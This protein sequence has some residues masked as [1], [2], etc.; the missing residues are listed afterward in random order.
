MSQFLCSVFSCVNRIIVNVEGPLTPVLHS[1]PW[2]NGES[3]MVERGISLLGK[4]E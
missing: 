2:D 1:G 3:G 4:R